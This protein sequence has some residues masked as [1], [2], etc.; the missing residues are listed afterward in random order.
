MRRLLKKEC[1]ETFLKQ[2]HSEE[3]REILRPLWGLLFQRMEEELGGLSSKGEAELRYV[4]SVVRIQN[5]P[6]GVKHE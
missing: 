5:E 2:F 6:S 4:S 3:E 1:K